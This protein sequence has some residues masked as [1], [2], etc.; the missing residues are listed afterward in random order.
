[1]VVRIVL[2]D[3]HPVVRAGLRALLEIEPDL[4]VVGEADDGA[5]GVRIS[6]QLR[7]DVVLVD[8]LLPDMDGVA[9]TQMLCSDRAGVQVLIL[10]SVNDDDD[11]VVRAVRAGAIGYVVKNADT[12]ALVD[13]IDRQVLDNC[14]FRRAPPLGLCAK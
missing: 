2:I 3:D 12:R 7:P 9:V 10:T 14:N 11:A 13:A 1:M 6:R 5:S 4:L 8:L